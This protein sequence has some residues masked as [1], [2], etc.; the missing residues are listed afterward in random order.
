MIKIKKG[1]DLPLAGVPA[2]VIEQARP[3]RQVALVGAD[4]IGMKPGMAV[5]VGDRVQRGQLL[6]TDKNCPAIRFTAPAS[7]VVSAIHRGA[8]RVFQSL[9]ID[10]NDSMPPLEFKSY[11]EA[12]LLALDAEVIRQ[13]L[14]ASGLWTSFRT[15]PFSKIPAPDSSPHSIFV[16]AIDTH[17]LAADPAVLIAERALA[18]RDGLVLLGKLTKG[19]LYVCKAEDAYMPVEAVLADAVPG[20]QRSSVISFSGPHPAGLAGTHIH[21]LDP[22]GSGKKTVWTIGYQDVIA[23]G[24]LFTRGVLPDERV[25]S[26]AGPAVNK[27]RLLR[28][29]PGASLDELTAGELAAGENRV[30]T[31]SVLGGRQVNGVT[32]FLGRYHQQVT[33][34]PE[35]RQRDFMGWL[36]P[37]LARHSVMGIYLS[38]LLPKRLLPMTTNTNGSERAMVP[39]GSYEMVMPLDVLITP[40]LRYLIVGD[41]DMAQKLGCLELDEEDLALCTY[42]CPGKYE[43]GPILR[44]V[45]T[46]IEKE[47]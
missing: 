39:V 23:I 7:G 33:V 1:L 45:L 47:G 30:I 46:R 26:L 3:V 9:V 21:Y 6:F 15:R 22:V 25:I 17:P 2:Q 29:R 13:Q 12:E 36:S 34:L 20:V 11:R 40:L 4:Y 14:L 5:Q 24:Q 41:T 35:G 31:G 43:Y 37:G 10:V 18:F 44:D 16:T 28:T 19:H 32:A 27:P 38:K 42:A 8:Q